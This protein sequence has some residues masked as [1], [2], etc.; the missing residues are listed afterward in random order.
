MSDPD[1]AN[2]PPEAP[3]QSV[4][5]RTVLPKGTLI[6]VNGTVTLKLEMNTVASGNRAE[7]VAANLKPE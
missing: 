3:A 7:I 5:T 6:V 2:P 4:T 1:P